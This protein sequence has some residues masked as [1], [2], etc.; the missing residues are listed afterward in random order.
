MEDLSPLQRARL[1]YAPTLPSSLAAPTQVLTYE[2]AA[3]ALD[4]A[5]D[6]PATTPAE[7]AR[8]AS[9]DVG[10]RGGR[11][12]PVADVFPKTADTPAFRVAP[13]DDGPFTTAAGGEGEGARRRLAPT[14]RVRAIPTD[15]APRLGL[16]FSGGPAPG[17]HNVAAGM[18]DWLERRKRAN[19]AAAKKPTTKPEPEPEGGEQKDDALGASS[20]A[21][22]GTFAP[23]ALIG[24]LGGPAGLVDTLWTPITSASVARFRNQGGF[25]L[26]GCG[27]A[28]LDSDAHFKAA[29]ETCRD[30]RLDGL[31]IVGGD[32]SNTNAAYLAEY[33]A[34]NDVR[35]AVV[36]VPKTIDDDF[37]GGDVEVCF[38]FDTCSK[39]FA[40]TVGNIAD[41]AR[42]SRR[43]YHFVRVMG[44]KSGRLTLECAL[45]TRPNLALIGEEIAEK[46][47]TLDRVVGA[48]AD[49]V[50]ERADLGLNHGVILVPEGLLGFT[51]EIAELMEAMH[52]AADDVREGRAPPEPAGEKEKEKAAASQPPTRLLHRIEA[53]VGIVR[54]TPKARSPPPPPRTPPRTPGLGELVRVTYADVEPFLPP[55]AKSV[56]S[57]LPRDI[58]D[59]MLLA[60]DAHGNPALSAIETE[61]LLARLVSEALG[62]ILTKRGE[63]TGRFLPQT[64]FCGYEGRAAQPTDF[65]ATYAYA[66]GHAA[67][68]L[69]AAGASGVVAAVANPCDPP[70]NWECS[71]V[72]LC[73]MLRAERRAGKDRLVIRKAVV[74]LRGAAFEAF[75]ARR[76]AWRLAD[77]YASPGPSQFFDPEAKGFDMP[78]TLVLETEA[79]K[80]KKKATEA[81][82]EGGGEKDD[83]ETRSVDRPAG[84]LGGRDGG[85]VAG[86]WAA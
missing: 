20:A 79:K 50:A 21:S 28:R 27:R 74:D 58:L 76:D 11:L 18:L 83:A 24:F 31:A 65:D 13:G 73:R 49:L 56:A 71:G 44:R 84:A 10:D 75:A 86:A 66:L 51:P 22:S 33:F 23:G 43:Y 53:A 69:A 54:E 2:E 61:K 4:P 5:S 68:S 60:R 8:R 6:E 35:C 78:T 29:A 85:C 16:I 37:R 40:Q 30:L 42:S 57:K 48:V 17:G 36:G 7:H 59:E 46:K 1:S 3:G 41:D 39:H 80:K 67:A 9:D 52:R 26:L 14:E 47:W 32:D 72:P 55:S 25:H 15:P 38:G 62:G 34:A 63:I 64:H 81:K 77:R 19:E 70:E 82:K 12:I 45:R